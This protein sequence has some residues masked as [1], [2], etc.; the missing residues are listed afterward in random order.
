MAYPRYIK[1]KAR[2]LRIANRLTIDE[3]AERMAIPRTT[4]YHWVRDL[5][6]GQTERQTR[7]AY[8]AGLASRR[9]HRGR[10]EA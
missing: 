9:I 10:R 1:E 4:I 7:A 2:E 3:L 5:P 6:I 8:R